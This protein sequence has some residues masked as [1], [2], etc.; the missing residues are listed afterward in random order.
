M[1]SIVHIGGRGP[2]GQVIGVEGCAN[3]GWERGR[4]IIYVER[5]ENRTEHRTLGHP[6][7]NSEGAAH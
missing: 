5:K 1:R 3:V 4:D 6:A 7:I 2:D